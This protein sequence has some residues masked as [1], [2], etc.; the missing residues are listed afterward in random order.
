M[1]EAPIDREDYSHLERIYKDL[2]FVPDEKAEPKEE[3]PVEIR[4]KIRAYWRMLSKSRGTVDLK[5]EELCWSCGW[6]CGWS[7]YNEF[8][9]SYGSRIRIAHTR[10][11][12]LT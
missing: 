10:I 4:E 2:V 12:A 11:S 1:T 6:S 9:S 8:V 5:K 3:L 7:A